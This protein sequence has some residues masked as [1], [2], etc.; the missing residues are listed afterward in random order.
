MDS[1]QVEKVALRPGDSH[2]L[3]VTSTGVK[4]QIT[5]HGY[6]GGHRGTRELILHE[7][8][9]YEI[10]DTIYGAEIFIRTEK[11]TKPI[12]SKKVYI[13]T[14]SG[15]DL[16]RYIPELIAFA[17]LFGTVVNYT[18]PEGY[19]PDLILTMAN[20]MEAEKVALE[21]DGNTLNFK[22]TGED[23]PLGAHYFK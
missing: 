10:Y 14:A 19:T 21:I 3:T 9:Q 20:E 22:S 11:V 16:S 6:Y 18:P 7:S 12:P 23:V 13:T 5:T 17:G 4:L 2:L 8:D 15:I 1:Y